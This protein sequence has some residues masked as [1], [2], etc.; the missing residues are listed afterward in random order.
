MY[1][2]TKKLRDLEPYQPIC[3]TYKI[4]LDANESYI[5]IP[6]ETIKA[7][8]ENVPLNRY[9]DP[10]AKIAVDAFSSF[11]GINPDNVTAGNGSDE[12]I[13]II[14]ACFLEKGDKTLCFSQDFSMYSF[15]RTVRIDAEVMKK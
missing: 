15:I 10:Y 2:L 6:D 13:S 8:M 1:E 3:G 12:L 5:K 4:R 7:A 11:F 9:P 14:T